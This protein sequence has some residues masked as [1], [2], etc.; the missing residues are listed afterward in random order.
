MSSSPAFVASD[1]HLGT[2]RP[3]RAAA[4]CQWLEFV[5]AR[6]RHLI[7]NG[8]IFD[9]WF[10]YE[11]VIPRGHTRTL[12]LLAKMVDSGIRVDF[13]GGNHDWWGGSYLE[14][15]VGVQFHRQPVR[16]EVAGARALVAH[17]DGLGPG[18][19][20]YRVLSSVL[21]NRLTCWAFRWVHPDLG[22]RVARFVSRTD[23]RP[24]VVEDGSPALALRAPILERW[25]REEL[26]ADPE[27]DLVLLG[28]THTPVKREV[29]PGRFYLNSGD[30][31]HHRTFLELREGS[32]P[33]LLTWSDPSGS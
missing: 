8:D 7:L 22:A 30:W 32:A 15:E 1:I 29:A 25:A 5:A 14:E 19:R 31:L 23:R 3:E 26:L 20:G 27:L 24:S 21:R 9:F 13:V 16:L 10:E 28:H 33:Q 4:F 17:G 6:S 12:G 18:D 11:S 2:G